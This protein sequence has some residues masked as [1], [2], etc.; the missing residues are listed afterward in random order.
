MAYEYTGCGLKDFFLSGGY[1]TKKTPYGESV[2]IND[3]QGLHNAIG[4][5][6]ADCPRNLTGTEFRFLRRELDLSQKSF[7]NLFNIS[8][9]TVANWE[10]GTHDLP[11]LADRMIRFLYLEKIS[12][13]N[14]NLTTLLEHLT[15]L[16]HLESNKV[17]LKGESSGWRIVDHVA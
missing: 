7:G 3:L 16:D 2:S 10:K 13:S 6:L 14:Q 1:T 4:R 9:Q 12:E 5:Y 8:D 15:D 17:T 11:G